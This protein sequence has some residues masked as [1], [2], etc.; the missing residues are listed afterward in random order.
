M[1]TSDTILAVI[2]VA[3]YIFLLL[4]IVGTGI[5]ARKKERAAEK[6]KSAEADK[7]AG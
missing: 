2:G 7:R 6:Q 5:I 3:D 1:P 4:F